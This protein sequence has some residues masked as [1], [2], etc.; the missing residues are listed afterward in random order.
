M[1]TRYGQFYLYPK[2]GKGVPKTGLGLPQS[3][4]YF[5]PPSKFDL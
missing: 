1:E 2:M 5:P 3:S 4:P